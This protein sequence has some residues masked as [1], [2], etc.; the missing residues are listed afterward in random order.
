MAGFC[1]ASLTASRAAFWL[2]D[3]AATSLSSALTVTVNFGPSLG[4]TSQCQT[5]LCRLGSLD[6]TAVHSIF[7]MVSMLMPRAAS[8]SGGNWTLHPC[9]A[10]MH[11]SNG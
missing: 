7:V 9:S 5:A 11:H 8:V 10:R 3:Q 1:K 4:V 6:S 2:S